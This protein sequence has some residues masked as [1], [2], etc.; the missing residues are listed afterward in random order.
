MTEMIQLTPDLLQQLITAAVQAVTTASATSN[1]SNRAVTEKPKRLTVKSGIN[2]EH[3]TYFNTRWNRYKSMTLL[4]TNE[5]IFI[6]KDNII[7]ICG[8][9]VTATLLFDLY[10]QFS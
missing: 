4:K 9:G 1:S 6:Y 10:A 3:W 5:F 7:I 2:Q 8:I